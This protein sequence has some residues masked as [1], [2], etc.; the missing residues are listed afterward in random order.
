MLLTPRL[1]VLEQDP[2]RKNAEGADNH[3]MRARTLVPAVLP[4]PLQSVCVVPRGLCSFRRIRLAGAGANA[5]RNALKAAHLKSRQEALPSEDG[6]LIVA[7]KGQA[8]LDKTSAPMAGVWGFAKPNEHKGRYLPESLA[9]Q[10][11]VDGLRLV[12]G[13]SGY[14]AQIWIDKNLAAS[15]WWP[16]MP[17]PAQWDVFIRSAQESLGPIGTVMPAPAPVPWRRDLSALALGREQVSEWLSPVN[18]GAITATLLACGYAFIGAQYVR[19]SMTLR[20]SEAKI[21]N[22]SE[23]TKLILSHQRRAMANMRYVDRYAVLGRNDT[24][25]R[26]LGEFATVLGQTDMTI[27]RVNIRLGQIDARL[28]GETEISVPDVVSL[29]E[30]AP[31]LEK[32]SVT[33]DAR[34]SV[35]VKADLSAAAEGL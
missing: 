16:S 34:G 9:Q 8:V 24:V 33:L 10:P 14:E 30:A 19:E 5:S 35:I 13:L 28:R 20:D 17:S 7:D 2:D 3:V 12:E 25:L 6:S 23:E 18:L 11:M 1:F 31:A 4:L 22:L 21:A 27:E 32:V 29:L 15:R 26:G